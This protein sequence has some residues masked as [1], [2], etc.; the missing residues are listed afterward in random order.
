MW[1]V[2]EASRNQILWLN[3][4]CRR[5]EIPWQPFVW[6]KF[7]VLQ[8]KCIVCVGEFVLSKKFAES[9]ELNPSLSDMRRAKSLSGTMAFFKTV[10]TGNSPS[11]FSLTCSK[12]SFP[13]ATRESLPKSFS[14]TTY[15]EKAC[16]F[17]TGQCK[18]KTWFSTQEF[19][20]RAKAKPVL[21]K[22]SA[23]GWSF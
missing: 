8:T 23:S 21:I 22:C 18:C 2:P 15:W 7:C 9:D 19:L 13:Q 5:R 16:L 4:N 1:S 20:L 10:P 6:K 14:G 11:A 3:T 12:S 17:W